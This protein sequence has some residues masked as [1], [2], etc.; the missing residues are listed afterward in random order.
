[1][2]RKKT[3]VSEL[4]FAAIM[5]VATIS[6]FV[7]LFF[8]NISVCV[9]NFPFSVKIVILVVYLIIGCFGYYIIVSKK[10]NCCVYNAKSGLTV[11]V[12]KGSVLGS[13][14][15]K[16]IH[17]INSFDTS[18]DKNRPESLY[19][20]FLCKYLTPIQPLVTRE[21]LKKELNDKIT[22]ALSKYSKPYEVGDIAHISINNDDF[23]LAAFSKRINDDGDVDVVD[24]EVE[25]R[26]R[27][28]NIL[29][30]IMND[31][32]LVGDTLTMGVLGY[33]FNKINASTY[34][35]IILMVKEYIRVTKEFNKQPF[36]RLVIRIKEYK[37][38]DFDKMSLK[39][40][41]MT[42]DF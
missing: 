37:D 13:S 2:N 41:N 42:D 4:I 7:S 20:E 16:L 23:I 40:E 33:R 12:E 1:M 3:T 27:I 39:L 28:S 9:Q 24:S 10:K 31:S 6:S 38:F 11:V 21:I 5:F 14:G 34:D 32:S 26:Q 18:I 17:C 29:T 36:R 8:P 25:Y 19:R 30:N 35:K 15:F 22:N